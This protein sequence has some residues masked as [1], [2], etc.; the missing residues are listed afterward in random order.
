M[1]EDIAPPHDIDATVFVRAVARLHEWFEVQAPGRN[2]IPSMEGLRG[3]SIMLVFLVHY[4]LAVAPWANPDSVTFQILRAMAGLG[5]AGVDLFFLISGFLIYGVLVRKSQP[6]G[7]YISRRVRRIYPVFLVVMAIYIVLSTI[8]P[9][10]RKLP[11]H[12]PAALLLVVQS[13]LL[14]PG[15]VQMQPIVG[16]AWSL[17]YEM[18][19]YLCLPLL[20]SVVA[21]R[22]RSRTTRVVFFI[23]L[24]GV[25]IANAVAFGG[26]HV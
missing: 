13:I 17:S 14:L 16:V 9:S 21:L 20:L 2:R 22:R 25:I 15:I 12:L 6:F 11:S 3:F 18:F 24:I 26:V 10:E 19:F 23:G 5:N 4:S 1:S 7:K 8:A